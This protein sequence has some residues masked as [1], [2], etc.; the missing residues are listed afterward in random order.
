[1]RIDHRSDA[2][3]LDHDT[4]ERLVA[5]H[6]EANGTGLDTTGRHLFHASRD[7]R[8]ESNW[9][10]PNAIAVAFDDDS[11]F[12]FWRYTTHTKPRHCT[13][14]HL[15]VVESARGT[16]LGRR[17]VAALVEDMQARGYR[18]LRL[19]ATS[20]SVG[21]YERLG[22]RW[23]GVSRAGR[24]FTY[25]DVA[26]WSLAPLPAAQRRYATRRTFASLDVERR[27]RL[28]AR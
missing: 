13:L 26:S 15:A 14:R 2:R 4:L 9:G 16:G 28:A 12:A 21:F 25:W 1:M 18:Y 20:G 7:W 24:P 23:H 22:M 5:H 17:V 10:R 3:R 27:A 6:R 8:V 11:A 19:F